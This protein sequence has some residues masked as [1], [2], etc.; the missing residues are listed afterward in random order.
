M[1]GLTAEIDLSFLVGGELQQ[2]AVGQHEVILHFFKGISI[3]V[4]SDLRLSEGDDQGDRLSGAPSQGVVLIGLLA[5]SVVRAS[6]AD[7]TLT[8]EFS[9]GST[10]AVYDSSPNFESYTITYDG[11]TIVV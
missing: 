6:G 5:S 8:M 9:D 1:Y 3:T 7:G 11:G 2:V 4:Q 10:L